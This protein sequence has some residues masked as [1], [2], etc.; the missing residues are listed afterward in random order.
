M[1][2]RQ[3]REWV[4][5]IFAWRCPRALRRG[6]WLHTFKPHS[7][8]LCFPSCRCHHRHPL[9]PSSRPDGNR[10]TIPSTDRPSTLGI[11]PTVLVIRRTT[12]AS[13][14]FIFPLTIIFLTSPISPLTTLTLIPT[15]LLFIFR[16]SLGRLLRLRLLLFSSSLL[17]PFR[18]F[19]LP[20]FS[21]SLSSPPPIS[22]LPPL[23]KPSP[24]T[25]SEEWDTGTASSSGC[26]AVFQACTIYGNGHADN[27]D[28]AMWFAELTAPKHFP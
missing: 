8:L 18:P 26:Y 2:R 23:P 13:I 4:G 16:I 10:T 11:L 1:C 28:V 5:D 21:T 27:H 17:R 24:F 7:Y 3:G 22:T 25:S 9:W 12:V 6:A 14:P 20:C 15:F 19:L